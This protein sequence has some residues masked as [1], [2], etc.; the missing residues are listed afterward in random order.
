MSDRISKIYT[1]TPVQQGMLLGWLRNRN[2]TQY[3]EQFS[4]LVEGRPK[5]QKLEACYQELIDRYDILRTIFVGEGVSCPQ[6]VVLRHRQGK[7]ITVDLKDTGAEN[8]SQVCA[9]YLEQDRKK[10]FD[11]E[12]DIPLRL[13]LAELPENKSMLV[14]SFHHIALDGW[15]FGNLVKEFMAGYAAAEPVVLPPVPQFGAYI[16]WC[17]QRCREISTGELA[18]YLEGF[19]E[20]AYL[21]GFCEGASEGEY[22]GELTGRLK[23]ATCAGIRAFASGFGCTLYSCIAAVILKLMHIYNQTSDAVIGSVV[24]G[25]QAPVSGVEQMAGMLINTLPLRACA[26]EG[27]L[28]SE[29]M[30]RTAEGINFLEENADASLSELQSR[31]SA[32]LFDCI[33][34][35]ENYP[36][37]EQFVKIINNIGDLPFTVLETDYYEQTDSNMYI[38]IFPSDEE[39]DFSFRFNEK[40]YTEMDAAC[41]LEQL[42]DMLYRL[43]TEG[44]CLLEDLYITCDRDYHLLDAV[45]DNAADYNEDETIVTMLKTAASEQKDKTAVICSG[46]QLSFQQLDDLSD[47]LAGRLMS[48]G[49]K[50]GEP[51]GVMMK[52]SVRLPAAL[53]AVMKAG[54]AYVP[55]GLSFPAERR[56]TMIADS[57]MRFMIA[58]EGAEGAEHVQIITPGTEAAEER[59]VPGP[60]ISKARPDLPAYILYTSGTTGKPKGV[61]IPHKAIY[62]FICSME[63][64]FRDS[65]CRAMLSTTDYTFDIFGLELYFSVKCGMTIAM[66][67]EEERLEPSALERI[68]RENSVDM[69]QMTPSGIKMLLPGKNRNNSLK[70]VKYVLTGGEAVS[71]SLLSELK[72]STEARIFNVY[73]PTETTVWSTICELTNR[74]HVLIGRPLANQQVYVL[75]GKMRRLPVN[76]PGELYIAGAG[77]GY[78]Y[79]GQAELTAEKF[80]DNPFGTGKI[81]RTGDIVR[82]NRE[83]MLE[84]IGR[85]DL[86]VKIRGHRIECDEVAVTISSCPGVLQA[87][88][89]GRKDSYGNDVL[90]GYYVAD[91]NIDISVLKHH[92][93][94]K[95]PEYMVPDVFMRIDTIPLTTS[96]KLNVSMLPDI[97]GDGAGGRKTSAENEK[98]LGLIKIWQDILD[99]DRAIGIDDN[100]FEIGGHSLLAAG[101]AAEVSKFSG[102]AFSVRDIFTYPTVRQMASV[103]EHREKADETVIPH[104]EKKE[105]YMVSDAQKRI[106]LMSAASMGEEGWHISFCAK[107]KEKPDIAGLEKA[108]ARMIDRYEILRTTFHVK[109]SRIVQH[110]HETA[111]FHI[112]ILDAGNRNPDPVIEGYYAG[113]Y[114]LDRLFL[115]RIGVIYTEKEAFLAVDF[116]HIISDGI[117]MRVFISELYARYMGVYQSSDLLQYKDYVYYQKERM[118]SEEYAQKLK[119]WRQLMAPPHDTAYI[120]PDYPR[121]L[122]KSYKAGSVGFFFHDEEYALLTEYAVRHNVT[123]FML[124]GSLLAVTLAKMTGKQ[125]VVIGTPVSGRQHGAFM[126]AMGLFI[127]TLPL[128]Y[129]V[130]DDMETDSY[131]EKSRSM[132][133]DCLERQEIGFEDIVKVSEC[134]M[135]QGRNPLFDVTFIMQNT[136]LTETGEKM[137]GLKR[138]ETGVRTSNQDLLFEAEIISGQLC[139]TLE[140]V[141]DL[142]TVQTA[143]VLLNNFRSVVMEAVTGDSR[144]LGELLPGMT[145]FIQEDLAGDLTMDLDD[146]F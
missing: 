42:D 89:A 58:D 37:G 96:G 127:N 45:N 110:V 132:V 134:R 24:S 112:D 38:S 12:R 137:E 41:F 2:S 79:L 66:A 13:S 76:V 61:I 72:G 65:N 115:F 82:M 22:R 100:F 71:D 14:W 52:R 31:F 9:Y 98:Q 116:H 92:V 32:E 75:D 74:E 85:K 139:L 56:N 11:L 48:L 80:P 36:Y 95:L 123:L 23:R 133:L 122:K 67:D 146:I 130:E 111:E 105:H 91:E 70:S 68:I 53:F 73:G 59:E 108:C 138:Y 46:Q 55:L 87:A 97:T 140:Y 93:G 113:E 114:E 120:L 64:V 104:V 81:Y 83:G 44:D 135:E 19:S 6:Q 84:F 34:A 20:T 128:R 121:G 40:A 16:R 51:V 106:Y 118:K 27:E 10:G 107:M 119:F 5:K 60:V 101:L 54:G 3:F 33:I 144:K 57:G 30:K 21:P 142:Y 78:G 43:E 39:I 131:M 25:R 117:S 102:A 35:F 90:A 99:S 103:L 86:Q 50:Q 49:V 88:A 129:Q 145:D 143:E 94:S 26:A 18:R 29:M 63:D 17:E 62:N 126:N 125:D 8:I 28:F 136:G 124:L 77:V 7:L 109:D 4:I 69:V 47:K 141:K 1:L 15:S